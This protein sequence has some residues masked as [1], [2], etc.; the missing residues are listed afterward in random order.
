M[1]VEMSAACYHVMSRTVNGEFLLGA[2]EKEAFRRMM[3]RMAQFSGVEILTY[4]LM[5]NHFHILLKVPEQEK[6]LRR[7]EGEEGEEKLLAHLAIVYSKAFMGQLRR[8]IGQL[9]E[10]GDEA[11]VESLLGRFKKRFCDMSLFVKELKERFSR[12]Y[13][14]QQ[15]RRGTLWMDRFKSVIVESGAA[16]ETMAAYID[17]NPVRAGI[18]DDPALYEWSGYGEATAGSRRARRG[19]CKVVDVPQDGWEGL[20]ERRYRCWLYADGVI[21]PEE[22]S[23]ESRG[24]RKKGFRMK[25]MVK[26]REEQEGVI[27]AALL[28]KKRV[29]SFSNG[30]AVGSEDFIKG[31]ATSYQKSFGRLKPRLGKKFGPTWGDG[32]EKDVF[33]M[34]K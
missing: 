9:R 22:H 14:K 4:A 18:V 29:S 33:V 8:E 24:R 19:L 7:F 21:V 5:D 20:G 16:L 12:W 32:S 10:L 3:W 1:K 13:N 6:W 17:L 34:R 31:V 25:Q 27:G 15:G 26:V 2:L 11:G 28:L 23:P 30:V